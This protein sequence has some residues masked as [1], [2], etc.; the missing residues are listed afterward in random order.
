MEKQRKYKCCTVDPFPS[1]PYWCPK[2]HKGNVF[3]LRICQ[4]GR[5][6]WIEDIDLQYEK[7]PIPGYYSLVDGSVTVDRILSDEDLLCLE[8]GITIQ[9]IG[10]PGHSRES[11][12]FLLQ[13]N[14]KSFLPEIPYRSHQ[15][16]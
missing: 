8:P 1:G 13:G 4:Q 3:L 9:V 6:D 12:C 16:L 2:N 15:M 10:V 11:L 7:R 14:R 5:A